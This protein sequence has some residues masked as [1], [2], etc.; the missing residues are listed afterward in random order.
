MDLTTPPAA[1]P[2]DLALSRE[3]RSGERVLWQGR[4]LPRVSPATFGIYLFAVPWTAFSLFWTVMAAGGMAASWES[5]GWLGLAFPLFGLPFIAVGMGMLSVPFLPLFLARRTLFAVT[6]ER[7]LRIVLAERLRTRSVPTSR[8]GEI[9]RS[10]RPDG[11][12]TLTIVTGSHRDSDGDRVT[13]KFTIGEVRDVMTVEQR[14]R[15]LQ[16]SPALSS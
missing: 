9:V 2:L 14:V 6:S 12:G 5:T 16:R 7:L 11:S 10:E 8:I 3:L 15:E 13:E 1:D 4:P